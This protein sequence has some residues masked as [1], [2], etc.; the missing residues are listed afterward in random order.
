[1]HKGNY[2]TISR[3]SR[4][5][6]GSC[7]FTLA[8]AGCKS[9]ASHC[10]PRSIRPLIFRWIEHSGVGETPERSCICNAR[11]DSLRPNRPRPNSLNAIFFSRAAFG[12]DRSNSPS[13]SLIRRFVPSRALVCSASLLFACAAAHAQFGAQ[14][15]GAT[16][17]NQGVT[18]TAS[19]AGTVTSVQILTLGSPSGDFAAGT[20][21][22]NCASA[23]FCAPGVLPARR[24][25]RLRLQRPV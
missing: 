17:G 10:W 6:P 25:S 7:A 16:S 22:A 9:A 4:I 14:P 1:M 2:E 20:G 24:P 15:V 23:T 18:V 13:R 19:T 8:S 21:A 12:D 11:L 5:G 3:C